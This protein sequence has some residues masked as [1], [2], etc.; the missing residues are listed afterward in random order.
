L[1]IILLVGS[2]FGGLEE[3]LDA[4][5]GECGLAKDAHNLDD[6]PADFEAVLD[7]GNETVCDNGD[8]YLY[9]N[10][11]LGLAPE[12]L[13]LKVLLNPLEEKFDLPPVLVE[14]GDVLGSKIE[15]VRVVCECPVNVRCIVNDASDGKGIVLLVPLSREAD[16]LVSQDVVLPLGQVFSCFDDVFRTELLP[17]DEECSRLFDG[18]ESGEVKV[19]SVKHIAGKRLVCE[20]VHSIDVMQ[21]CGSDSVEHRYLRDDVNLGV[22]LDAGFGTPEFCPTKYRY[23]EVDDCG[24]DSIEP[25]MQFKLLRE[26]PGLGNGD[27]VKGKLLENPVVSESA[28]FGQHLPVDR[29]MAKAEKLEFL[30]MGNCNICKF[31]ETSAAHKLAKHQNQQ[32]IPMRHRPA[33][34][35][36]VVSDYDTP[37]LPLWKEMGYLGKNELPYMHTCYD[38]ES[39]AKVSISKPGQ[40]IGRSKHCA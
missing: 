29:L 16:G 3:V 32:M 36:V 4:V 39:N 23:A 35:S 30:T 7:D 11:I 10:S 18:E 9:A 38:F 22:N 24:I 15:V 31:P 13:D 34:G 33:F 14:Q 28:G 17:Y 6:G 5:C 40:G 37:E 25:T 21:P 12:F 2:P 19:A 20:P 27:H 8:V 26:A 1:P